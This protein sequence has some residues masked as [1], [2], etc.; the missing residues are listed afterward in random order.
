MGLGHKPEN[1]AARARFWVHRC[2][3]RWKAVQGGAGVLGMRWWWCPWYPIECAGGG[4]FWGPNTLNH[5]PK[6]WF[7]VHG[8]LVWASGLLWGYKDPS[9]NKLWGRGMGVRYLVVGGGLYSPGDLSHPS[10]PSPPN[11]YPPISLSS[12]APPRSLFVGQ[13]VHSGVRVRW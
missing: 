10:S 7:G 4:G 11:S 13:V 9:S 8:E 2:K 5:A 6:A 1:R 3:L 12:Y